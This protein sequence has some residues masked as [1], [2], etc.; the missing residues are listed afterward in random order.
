MPAYIATARFADE[1]IA[2]PAIR[3]HNRRVVGNLPILPAH[4]VRAL[5]GVIHTLDAP[6]SY[7]PISFGAHREWTNDDEGWETQKT[8]RSR[9]RWIGRAKAPN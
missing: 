7:K 9:S 5:P 3:E 8:R 2:D 1:E 4:P 6:F